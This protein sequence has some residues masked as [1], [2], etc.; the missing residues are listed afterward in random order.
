M[1]KYI[2]NTLKT[3]DFFPTG[4]YFQ[5]S[6]PHVKYEHYVVISIILTAFKET[7]Y[8]DLTKQKETNISIN[9]KSTKQ[10]QQ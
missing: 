3:H 8:K 6:L 1:K 5:Q 10:N 7:I 4:I 9:N 2:R